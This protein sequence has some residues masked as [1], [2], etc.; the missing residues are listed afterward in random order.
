MKKQLEQEK[1]S[2]THYKGLPRILH[3]VRWTQHL[4]AIVAEVLILASLAM[5]GMD[6]SLGGT[7]AGIAQFKWSW[8]A[9]FALGVDTSFV[10]A[11]VRV[12]QAVYVRSWGA[13][14]WNLLLALGMSFIVFQPA[15]IQFLQQALA[16]NFSQA[17]GLLGINVVILAYAR[18]GVA[19]LLGA[20]LAMTNVE[21]AMSE[22]VSRVSSGRRVFMPLQKLMDRYAPIVDAQPRVIVEADVQPMVI[23]P[24]QQR[25]RPLELVAPQE[26]IERVRQALVDHPNASDRQ[27]AKA[28][29]VSPTT[30]GKYKKL[31]ARE[32]NEAV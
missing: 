15:A 12:R 31:L 27:I 14:T 21:S 11:W 22:E 20:I 29:N 30:A 3:G 10:I 17:L 6:A 24:V 16:I 19:V 4:L 26:P 13:F 7:M 2:V 32:H 25:K 1:P 23:Q 18:A 5:S 8:A 9:A 28:S